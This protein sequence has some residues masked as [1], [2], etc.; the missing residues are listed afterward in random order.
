MPMRALLEAEF[1][2]ANTRLPLEQVESVSLMINEML[3]LASDMVSVVSQQ[4]A[5][6]YDQTGALAILLL[7]MRQPL[8]TVGCCGSTP[9]RATRCSVSW[10]A[11]GRRREVSAERLHKADARA[12]AKPD[13]EG[14]PR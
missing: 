3:L 7:A 11:C 8:G 2:A 1:A 9:I 12:E 5:R 10:T 13:L 4:L 6:H 14:K